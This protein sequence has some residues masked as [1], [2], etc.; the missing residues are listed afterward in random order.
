MNTYELTFKDAQKIS[1]IYGVFLQQQQA[2]PHTSKLEAATEAM[3]YASACSL[4]QAGHFEKAAKYFQ[5]LLFY[6]PNQVDYL[7]G[8]ATCSRSLGDWS[9]TAQALG[10]ALYLEPE[11]STIALNWAEAL[12]HIGMPLIA[13]EI[14]K[15]IVQWADSP[16]DKVMQQRAQLLLHT[17]PEH[18]VQ[19]VSA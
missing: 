15:G 4:M 19:D 11:S 14:L 6:V 10:T 9:T 7:Q 3:L 13:K 17:I 16:E 18:V 5:F 2:L 1:Q 8:L 12:I